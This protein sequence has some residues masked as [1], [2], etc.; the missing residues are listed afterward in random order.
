MLLIDRARPTTKSVKLVIIKLSESEESYL[1]TAC[2][3]PMPPRCRDLMLRRNVPQPKMLARGGSAGL[4]LRRRSLR[5]PQR[6]SAPRSKK[7][8]R[9]RCVSCYDSW[10]NLLSRR[11]ESS[12][13]CILIIRSWG[14][15]LSA[16]ETKTI[17]LLTVGSCSK[18]RASI[19]SPEAAS[20]QP[21]LTCGPV[22]GFSAVPPAP[23]CQEAAPTSIWM[24]SA[25]MKP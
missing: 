10:C 3:G 5:S 4:R 19:L 9:P 8:A 23:C 25:T 6:P 11:F 16:R 24:R 18:S 20:E 14:F 21:A 17:A 2:P 12:S 22:F 7:L 13:P 1:E 15:T